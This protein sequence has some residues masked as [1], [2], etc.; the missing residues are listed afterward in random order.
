MSFVIAKSD[1]DVAI[2]VFF[3]PMG[4]FSTETNDVQFFP[5]VRLIGFLQ[6]PGAVKL[7]ERIGLGNRCIKITPFTQFHVC[8]VRE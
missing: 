1:S 4:S 8:A 2:S 5:L 7:L 3:F 6:I